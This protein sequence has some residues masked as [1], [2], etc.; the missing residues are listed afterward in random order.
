MNDLIDTIKKCISSIDKDKQKFYYDKYTY[1]LYSYLLCKK[2]CTDNSYIEFKKDDSNIIVFVITNLN[3]SDIEIDNFF[4]EEI[5][6]IQK[7]FNINL[8]INKYD[9]NKTDMI[10]SYERG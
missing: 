2:L 6:C 8:K 1:I 9:I 10:I 5:L 7:E 4:K 3:L